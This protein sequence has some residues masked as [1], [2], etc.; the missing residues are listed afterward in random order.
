MVIES[1]VVLL[2]LP[3][4]LDIFL[5]AFI[6]NSLAVSPLDSWWLLVVGAWPHLVVVLHSIL[7]KSG[8]S[9]VHNWFVFDQ[10]RHLKLVCY[11]G[12]LGDAAK[13]FLLASDR[14]ADDRKELLS[15]LT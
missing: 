14:F 6:T 12:Y 2:P 10:E 8:V 4:D 7:R 5:L 11:L 3:L 1:D 15:S 13:A 9:C